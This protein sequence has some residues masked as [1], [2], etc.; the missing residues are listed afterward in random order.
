MATTNPFYVIPLVAVAWVVHA[1]KG[2]PGP[3]ARSFGIFVLA[4]LVT[5]ATRT[6]LVLFLPQITAGSIVV[7]AAEGLRLAAILAIFG[8][9]NSV[10]D[11]FGVLRLAPRRFHEPALAAALA[12]SIAPRTME[13]VGTVREAQRLRGIS[14][15][16]LSSLPAL[17]VPVLENGMEQ[18]VTLAESMD[19]RG[20]GRGRRTRYRPQPWGWSSLAVV[21]AGLCA[22]ALVGVVLASR[23]DSLSVSGFPLEWPSVSAWLLLAVALLAVPSLLPNPDAPPRRASH[24]LRKRA[25]RR[26]E[27]SRP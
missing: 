1:A 25:R 14:T 4:G 15:N 6:A 23:G 20:H 13:A 9:F 3:Q 7:A 8:A 10:S 21:A 24:L 11:P 12:L 16:R 27:R 26:R 17:A 19:A 22:V 2:R 5:L 18:A